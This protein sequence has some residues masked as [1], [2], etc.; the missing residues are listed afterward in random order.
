MIG[1]T[2]ESWHSRA[3]CVVVEG[4][5]EN[6][7]VGVG[8]RWI[9]KSARMKPL[10]IRWETVIAFPLVTLYLDWKIG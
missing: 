4:V 7:S 10:E 1:A 2:P 5:D 9:L 3:M 8:S 6:K